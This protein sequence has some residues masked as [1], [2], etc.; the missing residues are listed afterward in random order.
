MDLSD[1]RRA[2]GLRCR[3]A[4]REGR[5]LGSG[6]VNRPTRIS[7]RASRSPA[8]LCRTDDVMVLHS[9]ETHEQGE[10]GQ[11]A[12]AQER[13]VVQKSHKLLLSFV[14]FPPKV[15]VFSFAIRKYSIGYR[16]VSK[17]VGVGAHSQLKRFAKAVSASS[18]TN[19]FWRASNVLTCPSEPTA[20]AAALVAPSIAP[21]IATS[22]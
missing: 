3:G 11:Q 10:H 13:Q 5:P 21:T 18:G 6:V 12:K 22:G 1:R 2:D 20:A 14:F 8:E 17:V 16:P 9:L 7:R 4:G 19:E 15:L